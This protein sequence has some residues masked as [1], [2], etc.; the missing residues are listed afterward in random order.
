MPW[1]TR[2]CAGSASRS[3]WP[4]S[5]LPVAGSA[6]IRA[7]SN[8]VLPA[9]LRPI[10]PHIS[11]SR[12][13]NE[14]SRMI[15]TGPIATLRLDTLSMGRARAELGAADQHLHLLVGERDRRRAV[16]DHGAVVER[17]HPVGVARYDVHVVLD[18]QHGHTADLER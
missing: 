17:Q 8:V 14:A 3:I 16:G 7:R 6:P 1:P 13:S 12:R 9:P 2:R 4:N 10:R 5:A 18:E 11:P 15:G